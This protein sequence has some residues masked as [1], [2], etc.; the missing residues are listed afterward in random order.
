MPDLFEW[1]PP[2][3]RKAHDRWDEASILNAALS[4]YRACVAYK[5]ELTHRPD[6]RNR[7]T[8]EID[9]ILE[10]PDAPP[11]AVELTALETFHGQ[12][13]DESRLQTLLTPLTERLR[14]HL[15]QGLWCILPVRAFVPGFDWEAALDAIAEFLIRVGPAVEAGDSRCDVPGVPFPVHIK[16]QPELRI[17]FRFASFAPSKEQIKSDLI[18]SV[19]KA[20]RH[21]KQR[22]LEYR[23][24]GWRTSVILDSGEYQLTSWVEPYR[25]FLA[26]EATVGSEHAND[27]VYCMTSDPHRIYCMAFKGDAAFRAALNPTNLKFGPEH[28]H[29]W[30]GSD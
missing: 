26:A 12:L 10:A 16:Y 25:A 5:Y 14:P 22:L 24:Q 30:Q 11:I 18:L 9:A 27:V 6:E 1:K 13:A 21:K 3:P 19:E 8:A 17:D 2:S 20:L 4:A 23:A 15:P 29:L 28:A 7:S